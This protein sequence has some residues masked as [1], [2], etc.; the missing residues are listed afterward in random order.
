MFQTFQAFSNNEG[1]RHSGLKN[2]SLFDFL[3]LNYPC[4]YSFTVHQATSGITQ[5][6]V[7]LAIATAS[8]RFGV[9]TA[10]L[11]RTS[12]NAA[13]K[14]HAPLASESKESLKTSNLPS[15]QKPL[16][17][18]IA[19]ILR[20]FL[21]SFA[22]LV[23]LCVILLA[24]YEERHRYFLLA[25]VLA[26]PGC[27]LR[28]LLARLNVKH[29]SFPRGTFVANVLACALDAVVYLLQRTG[30]ARSNTLGCSALQGVADGICGCL[31][32]VS[33]FAVEIR[34]LKRRHAYL[35]AGSSILAGQAIFVLLYGSYWWSQGLEAPCAFN[36]I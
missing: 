21:V 17:K 28:F 35:Y 27:F 12:W 34:G 25:L 30:A 36:N 15:R 9:H 6:Y 19:N 20:C 11:I 4:K 16:P 24:V 31:S 18:S 8:L 7:T 10:T 22:I 32:T 2:V 23:W 13:T 26:P 14:M 1:A 3:V 29:P 5:L 33:T